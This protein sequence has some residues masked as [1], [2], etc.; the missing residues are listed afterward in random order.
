VRLTGEEKELLTKH[1]TA[2]TEAYQLY[3]KGRYFL[4]KSTEADFRKSIEYFRQALDKDP[5]YAAAY[6]G[7]ADA[8]VQLGNYGLVPMKESYPRAREAAT[9]ALAIDEKLGE[10]HASLAFILTNYYWEWAEAEK[11][12]K[13]AI[14][15]SPNYAMAHNWYSQYLA[16]MGRPDEAIREARRAQ[17]LDPLSLFNNPGFVLFL[18]RQYDQAI[19]AARETLELDP[20][21]A[22][23][24]MVIGLS[25][26][27]KRMY[28]EGIS[29]LRRAEDNPD[30]RALLGYAYA[31]AGRR[32]E[33]RKILDEL[34]QLS[35]Q[36]YVASVPV[37]IIHIGLGEKEQALDWLEKGYDERLW[38]MGML[39]VNP[40]FDP[41]RSEPRFQDLIRRVELTP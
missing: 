38:E 4:N 10:A 33:A 1:S 29:E 3:L 14:E 17:E 22:V 9:R 5:T 26:V 12:F 6:A 30:S 8:Y 21:F 35:R 2:D 27:Q 39:K 13:R 28:E 25:Y 36:K 37:A 23:A 20:D 31:V 32:G 41:L 34:N 16:F 11:Q 19:A 40:V 15:L 7:L 24:H 18:A